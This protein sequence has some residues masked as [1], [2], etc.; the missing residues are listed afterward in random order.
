MHAQR[1]VLHVHKIAMYCEKLT[2]IVFLQTD[3]FNPNMISTKPG[4]HPS[5]QITNTRSD[6][7]GPLQQELCRPSGMAK[8]ALT[9][10]WPGL[11]LLLERHVW[12]HATICVI[13]CQCC[14]FLCV[15]NFCDAF[16]SVN[17]MPE[18]MNGGVNWAMWA[19]RWGKWTI[20]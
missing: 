20:S 1:P 14:L 4:W 8:L 10:W 9:W 2:P 12:T 18:T 7:K 17:V 5:K 11:L 13:C 15:F 6:H 16:F 3:N 19:M